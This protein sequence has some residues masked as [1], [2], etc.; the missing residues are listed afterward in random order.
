MRITWKCRDENIV[1]ASKEFYAWRSILRGRPIINRRIIKLLAPFDISSTCHFPVLHHQ[2]EAKISCLIDLLS[3]CW[4]FG[5]I[6]ATFLHFA[7]TTV[8]QMPLSFDYLMKGVQVF[9]RGER[10]QYSWIKIKKF[11]LKKMVNNNSNHRVQTLGCQW[12]DYPLY[13]NW[14]HLTQGMIGIVAMPLPNEFTM[15]YSL[16]LFFFFF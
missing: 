12:Y 1:F 9:A 8:K 5:K 15:I 10:K 16:S 3:R 11:F 7:A 2:R 14:E 6:D 4:L 13:V